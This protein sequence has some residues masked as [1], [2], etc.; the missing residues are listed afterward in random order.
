MLVDCPALPAHV[1]AGVGTFEGLASEDCVDS[2]EEKG[3]V[4]LL[5]LSSHSCKEVDSDYDEEADKET[6]STPPKCSIC[7]LEMDSTVDKCNNFSIY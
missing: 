7:E 4:L 3:K 6:D 2:D 5:L 1:R